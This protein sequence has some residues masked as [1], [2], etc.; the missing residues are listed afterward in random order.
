MVVGARFRAV[1]VAPAEGH[2]SSTELPVQEAGS[3]SRQMSSE[4]SL[5][6]LVLAEKPKSVRGVT[7]SAGRDRNPVK[8][9]A[10]EH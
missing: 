9:L 1:P 2:A 7:S 6:I 10:V 5:M 4:R 3:A 8:E